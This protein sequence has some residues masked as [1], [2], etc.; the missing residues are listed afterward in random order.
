M[1]SCVITDPRLAI[2]RKSVVP[3]AGVSPPPR[4]AGTVRR[5]VSL[6]TPRRSE[7]DGSSVCTGTRRPLAAPQLKQAVPASC[8]CLRDDCCLR[9]LLASA[10]LHATAISL[11]RTRS[12][13]ESVFCD[14]GPGTVS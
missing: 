3:L 1:L 10:G 8:F 7:S 2:T 14:Q 6:V 5:L 11:S 13:V 9:E 12:L 4:E